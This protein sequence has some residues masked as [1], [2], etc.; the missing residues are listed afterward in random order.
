MF[1]EGFDMDRG[2]IIKHRVSGTC[3]TKIKGQNS[4]KVYNQSSHEKQYIELRK[5]KMQINK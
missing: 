1:W 2:A 5:Q 3:S 4:C